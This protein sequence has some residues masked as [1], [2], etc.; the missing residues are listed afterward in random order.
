MVVVI[1]LKLWFSDDDDDGEHDELM[2]KFGFIE[3]GNGW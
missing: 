3:H 1:M 2:K